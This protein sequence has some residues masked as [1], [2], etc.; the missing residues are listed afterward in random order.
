MFAVFRS[1]QLVGAKC[2]FLPFRENSSTISAVNTTTRF[3][4]RFRAA[5]HNRTP[6]TV[7][8]CSE[9]DIKVRQE[10]GRTDPSFLRALL[11]KP[12]IK[13]QPRSIE[14]REP[15]QPPQKQTS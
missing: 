10:L 12:R 15:S 14:I 5:H 9:S 2:P 6:L 4:S 1:V 13:Y 3:V 8:P 7:Y 11:P